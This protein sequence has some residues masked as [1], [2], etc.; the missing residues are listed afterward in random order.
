MLLSRP[1]S[2]RTT[3]IVIAAAAALAWATAACDG[4]TSSAANDASGDILEPSPAD[5]GSAPE[6][7]GTNPE[8]DVPALQ[9]EFVVGVNETGRNTPEYFRELPEGADLTM[10]FGPQGLWMVVLA[11]RTHDLI[12][13]PL[14]L[15]GKVELVEGAE[16]LGRLQ[17]ADQPLFPGGDGWD[18]YYNFFLVV[19]VETR[20]VAGDQADITLNVR[21]AEGTTHVFT[22]RVI[23]RGGPAQ[24]GSGP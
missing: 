14:F 18:Y 13:A 15:D 11:F 17:L 20:D 16:L 12:Q 3:L 22:R 10:E 2:L 8:I 9:G 6:V 24:A 4:E 19:A 23:L 1:L 5:D 7:S 21:S